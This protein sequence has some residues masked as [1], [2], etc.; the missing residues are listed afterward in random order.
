MIISLFS[1]MGARGHGDNCEMDYYDSKFSTIKTTFEM[2]HGEIE[3]L[4]NILDAI[5]NNS[6]TQWYNSL[7][8][9]GLYLPP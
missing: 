8:R 3:A 2:L 7:I 4:R 1:G 5:G 9:T 6:S